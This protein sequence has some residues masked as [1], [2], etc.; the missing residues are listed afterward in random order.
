MTELDVLDMLEGLA[1]AV[2]DG[3]EAEDAYYVA[4]ESYGMKF[5]PATVLTLISAA[6]ER[7]AMREALTAIMSF[8]NPNIR[9]E[10][11]RLALDAV[12]NIA[13]QALNQEQPA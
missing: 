11:P 13:R 9:L 5:S 1:K 7:D 12:A 6:R 10:Q 3:D 2:R 8:A 4:L